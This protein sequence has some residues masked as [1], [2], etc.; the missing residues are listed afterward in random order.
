MLQSDQ[1]VQDTKLESVAV[2]T[3]RILVVDDEA[4]V[5]EVIVVCLQ[6]LGGWEVLTAASGRYAL[7]QARTEKLD[8]IVLDGMMPEMNGLAFLQYL[9]A[10]PITQSIPVVLLTANRDL[11]DADLLPQ[12]GVVLILSKPF[13]PIDLVQQIAQALG[14]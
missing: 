9:H 7:H 3:R 2:A 11:P 1:T 8:A 14:W 10:D 4:S 5:R 12:L 6:R 13:F